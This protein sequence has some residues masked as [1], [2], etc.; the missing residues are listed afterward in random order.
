MA[1]SFEIGLASGL[2]KIYVIASWASNKA[3]LLFKVNQ[4]SYKSPITQSHKVIFINI[5]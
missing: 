5:L 1:K 4:I 3:F 2:D